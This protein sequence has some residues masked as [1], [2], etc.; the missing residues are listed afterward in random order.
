VTARIAVIGCGAI[1]R[2]A[3]IPA[4]ARVGAEVVA[5]SSRTRAS[6][7]AARDEHGS[8]DVVNDW[9][10]LLTRDDVDAVDICTPNA[11]HAEMAVAAVAA[12][13]HVLVEKPIARTVAEADAMVAAARHAGVLLVTAHNLRFAAPFVAARDAVAK[14][15]VGTV[16]GV[17][18]G[19]GHSGPRAWSPS[20]DWFFDPALAGGGALID[21]G[22]HMAD[23]LRAVVHDEVVEVSA[24]LRGQPGQ[25]EESATAALRFAGETVGTLQAS[26]IV[27]PGPDLQLT[28]FGTDGTLHFDPARSLQLRPASGDA[29][30]VTLP[31]SVPDLYAEFVSAV[32]GDGAPSVTGNDG[33]AA[34]AIVEAAYRSASSGRAEAVAPPP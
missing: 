13:K 5:L 24:L 32:S 15:A 6:A 8:G 18:A 14:G 33:R 20:S 4:F 10:D 12:G 26:W 22:I 16:T 7:E 29:Y 31:T 34:L 27:H 3:H 17:R 21:L 9:R 23:L 11:L 25:V 2:R 28:V 30:A 19:F 1:A